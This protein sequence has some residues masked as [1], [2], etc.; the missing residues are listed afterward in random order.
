MH[1]GPL[2]V[3]LPQ[4]GKPLLSLDWIFA[5]A[6]QLVSPF[7]SSLC[8]H[9]FSLSNQ[10]DAMKLRSDYVTPLIKIL[11]GPG[12]RLQIPSKLFKWPS[13]SH[14]LGLLISLTS[15]HYAAPNTLG[16]YW[17][18]R[19]FP[20]TGMTSPKYSFPLLLQICSNTTFS[21]TVSS[22]KRE[23]YIKLPSLTFPI[24]FP[25]FNFVYGSFY[26]PIYCI[27]LYF[28]FI[29]VVFH[30]CPSLHPGL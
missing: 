8:L 3:T 25:L 22:W 12:I 14:S 30:L 17:L 10:D 4:W 5:K 26:L 29:V 6:S 16:T 15:S 27:M 23:F 9:P 21:M 2:L 24:P 7:S 11:Q 1:V 18:K 20:F 19:F 13:K 28:I